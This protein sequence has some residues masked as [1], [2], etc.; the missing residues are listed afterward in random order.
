VITSNLSLQETSG[1]D[2][3]FDWQLIMKIADKRQNAI[4]YLCMKCYLLLPFERQ[5]PLRVTPTYFL[6]L[7]KMGISLQPGSGEDKTQ[8]VMS[9]HVAWQHFFPLPDP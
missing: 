4:R 3:S 6:Q 2:E 9:E 5:Q 8:E 7:L 1:F